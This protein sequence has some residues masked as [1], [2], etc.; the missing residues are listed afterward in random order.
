MTGT[1]ARPATARTD[2]PKRAALFLCAAGLFSLVYGASQHVP[3]YQS[4]LPVKA[5][6]TDVATVHRVEGDSDASPSSVN[7]FTS[8]FWIRL[9]VKPA[10]SDEERVWKVNAMVDDDTLRNLVDSQIVGAVDSQS[11][12]AEAFEVTRADGSKLVS[13]DEATR[14]RRSGMILFLALG[15]VAE[16]GALILFL[17]SRRRT[18]S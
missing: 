2:G 6:V 17:I 13:Y 9:K 5:T 11:A 14:Q 4:L 16:L 1:N 18:A 10:A 8:N 7:P 3:A 15:A 12:R